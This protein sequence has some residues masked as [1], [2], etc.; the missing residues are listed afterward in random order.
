V[1]VVAS[2]WAL[3]F[4]IFLILGHPP[5]QLGAAIDLPRVSQVLGVERSGKWFDEW[6]NVLDFS[7]ELKDEL[8]HGVGLVGNGLLSAGYRQ[9][10]FSSVLEFKK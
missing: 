2:R 1:V 10:A 6:R 7:K 3:V 8:S 9:K 5:A 4:N